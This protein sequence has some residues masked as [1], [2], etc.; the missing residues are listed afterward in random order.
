VRWAIA[1]RMS[2]AMAR[3]STANLVQLQIKPLG[4]ETSQYPPF[5]EDYSPRGL[6]PNLVS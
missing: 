6:P 5:R 4:I 2:S 1:A 3:R